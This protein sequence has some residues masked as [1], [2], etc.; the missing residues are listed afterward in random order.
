MCPAPH[1]LGSLEPL[2]WIAGDGG[3]LEPLL[4]LVSATCPMWTEAGRMTADPRGTSWLG[5][6][7][8][9]SPGRGEG[10]RVQ[11]KGSSHQVQAL[12]GELPTQE[13]GTHPPLGQPSHTRKGW[14]LLLEPV[15]RRR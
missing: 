12:I 14:V 8:R 7:W 6:R 13:L 11:E 1:S 15:G 10:L 5:E 3:V 9:A 2:V 4:P